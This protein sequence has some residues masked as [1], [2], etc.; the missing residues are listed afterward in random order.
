MES[1]CGIILV[2]GVFVYDGFSYVVIYDVEVSD[3][4]SIFVD[5]IGVFLEDLC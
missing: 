2:F 5:C 1:V 4:C 3:L